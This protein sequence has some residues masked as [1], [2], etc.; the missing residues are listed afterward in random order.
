MNKFT[1]RFIAIS[2]EWEV[3]M[4]LTIKF[5]IPKTLSWSVRTDNHNG[6]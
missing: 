2:N 1:E 5:V 3:S 4:E 6:I